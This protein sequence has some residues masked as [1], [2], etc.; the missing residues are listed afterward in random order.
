MDEIARTLSEAGL[1]PTV[2]GGLGAE[3]RR[4]AR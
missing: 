4:R 3:L 2:V 1:D